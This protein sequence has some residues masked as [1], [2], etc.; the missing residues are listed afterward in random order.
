MKD[1]LIDKEKQMISMTKFHL[2][3]ELYQYLPFKADKA[4]QL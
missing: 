2:L 3:I 1:C 4:P